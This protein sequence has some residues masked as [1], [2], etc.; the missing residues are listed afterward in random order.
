MMAFS[1]KD[2][3]TRP[4]SEH[5][6][7]ALRDLVAATRLALVHPTPLHFHGSLLVSLDALKGAR[8]KVS[9]H[10]SEGHRQCPRTGG[11]RPTIGLAS[12]AWLTDRS[13]NPTGSRQPA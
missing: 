10:N 7:D 5:K 9:I 11:V 13:A 3:A 8:T 4:P 1:R 2:T 12:P 6:K